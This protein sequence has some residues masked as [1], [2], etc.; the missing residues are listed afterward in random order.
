MY[1]W[2]LSKPKR[3]GDLSTGVIF[4]EL[5]HVSGVISL[6]SAPSLTIRHTLGSL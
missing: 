4:H 5:T 1:L 6:F 3:D 2:D